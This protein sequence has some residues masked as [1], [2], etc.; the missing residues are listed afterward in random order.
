VLQ[1][2]R[3]Q[4]RLQPWI[5]ISAAYVIA[6]QIVIS[7]LAG[8]I[9][10]AHQ[11]VASDALFVICHTDGTPTGGQHDPGEPPADTS[12]CALCSLAQGTIVVLP[13]DHD[14][15]IVALISFSDLAPSS[16]D[17]I[18]AFNRE[19]SAFPRGPPLDAPVLG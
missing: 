12:Q 17:R 15:S 8:G 2:W 19:A 13:A 4:A 7:G 18:V 16:D 14:F 1:F 6:L 11:G 9:M 10:A 3:V 5:A